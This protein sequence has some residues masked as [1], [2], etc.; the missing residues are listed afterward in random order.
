MDYLHSTT[1]KHRKGKH[2]TYE[3]RVIIQIRLKDNWSAP[4]IAREIGCSPNT[5]RNEIKRGT[6]LLRYGKMRRYKVSAGQ[7]AYE[8]NRQPCCRHYSL[9]EK[10]DFLDYVRRHFYEDHWSLD[11]CVGRAVR[12][13]GFTREQVVCTKT[14]YRYVDLGLLEIKNIDLP[15]KVKRSLKEAANRQN[16]KILGRSI[17]E[18]PTEINGRTEFGHWE[19][20][21]VIGA[22]AKDDDALLTLTERLTREYWMIRVPG[23][24]PKGVMKALER[25]RSQYSEHWNEIFKTITTDNGSEFSKLSELE[26]LSKTL[27]Y[28]AHPYAAYEKGSVER[29]N[30]LIRRF[31]PK[32]RRIDSFS[33]EQILQIEIWCNN[34]PRRLLGYRTPDE[35]FEKELDQIYSC[36]A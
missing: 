6:V 9:L 20:D 25:I 16:K 26:D 18:R 10:E 31:I 35:L 19:A 33:D 13:D 2:L 8:R 11:A 36:V 15:E 7:A 27:V 29:H 24:N 28:F 23:R 22:K 3:E 21:L 4:Q 1:T 30:G 12:E 17:E 14:L 34:L 5:I 32:G